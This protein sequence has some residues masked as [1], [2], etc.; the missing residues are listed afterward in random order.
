MNVRNE[1]KSVF[2]NAKLVLPGNIS[3]EIGRD[4]A[5]FRGQ[6]TE[7]SMF[8]PCLFYLFKKNVNFKYLKY[9]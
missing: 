8:T 4:A 7:T 6:K 2:T 5:Q 3:A 9:E 1:I